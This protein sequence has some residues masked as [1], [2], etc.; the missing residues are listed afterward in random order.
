MLGFAGCGGGGSDDGSCNPGT[1]FCEC[2]NGQCMAG[3]QCLSNFCVEAGSNPETSGDGD[4]DPGDG[5]PGDGDPGDGDPG[6][7]DPGD[8]DPGDGDPGDGDPGDGDP[9]DGD[10]DMCD[11]PLAHTPPNVVF[12]IDASN[13]MRTILLDHDLN[14]NTAQ[15]PRWNLVINGLQNVLGDYEGIMRAGVKRFPSMN[16]T[17]DYNESACTTSATLEA[18][19]ALD[20]AATMLGSIPPNYPSE[21]QV[22]GS[23]PTGRGF[24]AAVSHLANQ[25]PTIPRAIVLIVD[26]IGACTEGQVLPDLLEST[27]NGLVPAI[28]AAHQ[29]DA[30]VTHVLGIQLANQLIGQGVDGSPEGNPHAWANALA[31]AGGAPLNGATNYY[32]ASS[33]SSFEA[34][35]EAVLDPL[36]CTL[37]LNSLPDGPPTPNEFPFVSFE[38]DNDPIPMLDSCADGNGWTWVL[39]GEH[40]QF[41]GSYCE[42]FKTNVGELAGNYCG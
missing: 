6:D 19:V 26:S 18:N 40:V 15:V 20:N 29:E 36:V 17:G 11:F 25:T 13:G 5:D 1:Y 35:L 38:L 32:D 42:V 12:A 21:A 22:K 33:L 4:G 41:C 2:F 9:G 10:G 27:D 34:G 7:G 37:D 23:S 8:G 3:L 28:E 30:I 31:V 39:L 24:A 16:A 14:A